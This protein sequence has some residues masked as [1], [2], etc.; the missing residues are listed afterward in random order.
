M[1]RLELNDIQGIIR[2]GY[3]KLEAAYFLLLEIKDASLAKIWLG[4][5]ADQIRD[6]TTKPEKTETC[7]NIAFT[8]AGF[9]A[10]GLDKEL[11]KR[12]S[13]E[14][15]GG[16]TTD[17]RQNILGDYGES[18]PENWVWGGPKT[19]PVH[20]LL[21][22]YAGD[23][24]E[25][26]KLYE[27]QRKKFEE[28]GLTEIHK[29]DTLRLPGQKEHFGFHDGIGQPTISGLLDKVPESR[30]Q[31]SQAILDDGGSEG[32]IVAAGE[33]ILGYKNAY[34]KMSTSPLVKA[35]GNNGNLLPLPKPGDDGELVEEDLK[36]S[37]DFGRNGS[38]L[39]FRQLR[40]NVLD[41][42]QFI[43]E[44]TMNPDG[45]SNPETRDRLAAK[46]VGRWRSGAPLVLH[47]DADPNDK[48][49]ETP[50]DQF[51]YQEKDPHG[52]RCPIA[53]HVRRTN[54][55]DSQEVQDAST[56]EE[57]LN[58]SNKHRIIRRGRSYGEPS[59][60]SMNPQDFLDAGK[61]KGEVGLQFICFNANIGR[62][63]EFIQHTW[64]NNPKFAGLYSEADPL[65]GPIPEDGK[66][67]S[68]EKEIFGNFVEPD[69]P[70]RQRVSGLKRFVDVRGG[71]YFFMPGIKA[72]RYLA[73]LPKTENKNQ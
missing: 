62:Q 2:R 66:A 47:P 19:T 40:Q 16:M 8:Q 39:V 17:H 73:K 46:M 11:D 18:A 23:E 43:D 71:A 6:G 29:L 13:I 50:E 57:A 5:L 53:S 67:T 22:L 34:K 7:V 25:L 38:Y 49:D 32:N 36:H 28:G 64:I 65:M 14:F 9:E 70:V 12:F 41:F 26:E 44:K 45:G 54:P 59:S 56:T 21:L 24:D 3:G 42:W 15:E 35:E 60:G 72:I 37:P 68:T 31:I 33:F 63:F 1:A 55:R 69:E 4:A 51:V 52:D 20:V 58:I 27:R 30:Q 10:L 61:T 48:K